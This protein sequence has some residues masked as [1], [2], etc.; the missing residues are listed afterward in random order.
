MEGIGCMFERG[1]YYDEKEKVIFINMAYYNGK[2]PDLAMEELV[3]VIKQVGEKVY[4]VSNWEGMNFT[5]GSEKGYNNAI[6]YLLE[7]VKGIVRYGFDNSYMRLK[8]KA[9]NI[10]KDFQGSKLNVFATKE[11]ALAAIKA[12]KV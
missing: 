2:K 9:E 3:A 6:A 5:P 10:K 4:L 8:V 11:E 7:H 1:C 12:G